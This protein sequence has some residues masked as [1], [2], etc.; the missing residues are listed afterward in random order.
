MVLIKYDLSLW[1]VEFTALSLRTAVYIGDHKSSLS[2][3]WKN[4]QV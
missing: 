1:E 3:M 4:T 2:S